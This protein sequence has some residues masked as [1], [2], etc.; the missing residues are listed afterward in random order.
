[1]VARKVFIGGLEANQGAVTMLKVLTENSASW[2]KAGLKNLWGRIAFETLF[3]GALACVP[4][5]SAKISQYAIDEVVLAQ[6]MENLRKLLCMCGGLVTVVLVLKYAAAWI[7]A[8]TRQQCALGARR[9][10]WAKWVA[11]A[12][13]EAHQSGEVAN[14][15]LGDVYTVGDIAITYVSTSIVSIIT[16]VVGLVVLFRV[17]MMLAW[18]AVSFIPG[19]LLHYFIF[20]KRMSRAAREVRTSIDSLVS[21]IVGRWSQLDDIRTL[22]GQDCEKRMFADASIIQFT[23]GVKSLFVKNLSSGIA[24]TLMVAWALFLFAVGAFLILRNELTL[25]EL[26]SVQMISGQLVGPV[27]RLL[28]MNLSL[29]VAQVAIGRLAEIENACENIATAEG[30]GAVR[31]VEFELRDVICHR[32]EIGRM[33]R[34]V[35][36]SVPAIG[37]Q[38]LKGCNGSGKSSICRIF[39]GLR[40]PVEGRYIVNRNSVERSDLKNVADHVLLLTHKPYFFSGTIRDN[41]MYGID[42]EKSDSELLDALRRVRLGAWISALNGGL[43]YRLEDGGQNLSQGQRQRLNCARALLRDHGVVIVDEALSG[44]EKGDRAA[45][46]DELEKGRWLIVTQIST[47]PTVEVSAL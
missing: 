13:Q 15:L 36:I 35:G 33:D 4:I 26:I 16:L 12:S 39:A 7:S 17:N 44:V 37:R 2:L 19:F 18:I 21:F 38:F 24:E 9:R 5:V 34:R 32:S 31:P 10:L 40:Y 14:R 3:L 11:W 23:A 28:N 20:G 8:M 42:C 25:G 43:A 45:I 22:R 6:N 1:M 47:S 41:L 30:I 46:L 27:Q 29:N